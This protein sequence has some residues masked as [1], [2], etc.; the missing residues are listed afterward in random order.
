MKKLRPKLPKK[1][2]LEPKKP[3]EPL[4]GFTEFVKRIVRVKP[5]ELKPKR[6]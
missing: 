5:N 2:K 6:A 3:D 1:P 4:M